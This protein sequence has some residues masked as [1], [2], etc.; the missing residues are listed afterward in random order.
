MNKQTATIGGGCFWCVEA[1]MKRINGVE[2]VQSGYAGGH[3]PA[4]SYR[5]VCEGRT[6]HAE[7]TQVTFD[8]DV[9]SYKDLLSIFMTS[10]DPTTHNRQGGDVGT[11][12]RSIILYHDSEQKAVAE[13]L[14]AE[15]KD[16]FPAPIVT[17]VVPLEKFFPA[18]EYHDN[19]YDRNTEAAYCTA[20]IAPKV[21]KLRAKH[22]DKL[23][24]VEV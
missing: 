1:I 19:Y 9:I 16:V 15:L 18:E 17:E 5:E 14:M 3:T 20:V 12:Y 7:V 23:K 10:H 11:Q 2:K 8:A 22:A 21:A 6:G 13:G 4:P 24:P